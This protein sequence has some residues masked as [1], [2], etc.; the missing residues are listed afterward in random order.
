MA[1]ISYIFWSYADSSDDYYYNGYSP[2]YDKYSGS[3]YNYLTVPKV[4][5]EITLISICG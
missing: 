5:A 3:G 4:I 2:D 1:G